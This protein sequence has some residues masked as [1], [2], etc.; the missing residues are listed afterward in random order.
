MLK[1]INPN[2]HEDHGRR[3]N[4]LLDLL[5]IYHNFYL[6]PEIQEKATFIIAEDETRGV[7]GGAVLYPQKISSSLELAASDTDEETLGKMFS[8][9]QPKGRVYWIARICLCI[10]G[11]KGSS[12]FD[13]LDL[14]LSFYKNLYKALTDFGIAED[15]EY[16]SF[17]LYVSNTIMVLPY[18]E[19]PY[20]LEV[21]LTEDTDGFLHG[22]L[23]LKGNKF[24]LRKQRKHEPS[25]LSQNGS[26]LK[27]RLS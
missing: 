18:E 20:L 26:V 22:I 7:Y 21:K 24:R 10:G 25:S 4:S 1:I 14:C 6:S 17:T 15:I 9:F 3:I 13:R 2:L 27:G 11:E 8:A 12:V 16:L 23:S 5:K 19:W